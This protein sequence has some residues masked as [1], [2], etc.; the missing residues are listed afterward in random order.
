MTKE[1]IV[2]LA[3]LAVGG[4]ALLID[5]MVFSNPGP[6]QAAANAVTTASVT[7]APSAGVSTSASAVS[8]QSEDSPASNVTALLA[9]RLEDVART[10]SQ[11]GRSV[12]DAFAVSPAWV[13]VQTQEA[14][15]LEQV[16]VEVDRFA[17]E[18]KLNAVL[19]RENGA[20]A[21]VDGQPLKVGQVVDG[22]TLEEIHQRSAV[23][24]QGGHRTELSLSGR[25]ELP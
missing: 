3:V 9:R 14:A 25:G 24:S 17:R 13:Q 6:S 8:E 4:A 2:L 1:R 5:R 21:I 18:H 10:Q 7:V 19:A 15:Q 11:G 16:N 23:F 22:F 20:I 12:R